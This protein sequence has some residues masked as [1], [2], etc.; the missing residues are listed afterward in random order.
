M[1]GLIQEPI[2]CRDVRPVSSPVTV[3]NS[4]IV[5][6]WASLKDVLF[7]RVF[8]YFDCIRNIQTNFKNSKRNTIVGS[9]ISGLELGKEVKGTW[10]EK[11]QGKNNNS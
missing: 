4:I 7:G 10:Q 3:A 6:L 11:E 9:V 5:D 8:C 1:K 2:N